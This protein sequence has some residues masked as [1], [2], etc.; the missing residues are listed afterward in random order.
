MSRI[1]S[2]SLLS[3]PRDVRVS[4]RSGG[5]IT[6]GNRNSTYLGRELTPG[7]LASVGNSA[8][9]P[10][11]SVYARRSVGFGRTVEP[12]HGRVC[13]GCGIEAPLLGV[14]NQCW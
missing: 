13:P 10:A 14:C 12:R 5:G 11:A 8:N 7:L 4:P 1:Y 9:P 6:R 3:A 2:T